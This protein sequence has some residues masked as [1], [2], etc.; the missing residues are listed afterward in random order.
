MNISDMLSQNLL[1]SGVFMRNPSS[2]ESSHRHGFTVMSRASSPAAILS[3][4]VLS[5]I[6]RGAARGNSAGNDEGS[7]DPNVS[8]VCWLLAT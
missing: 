1:E 2:A 5:I 3:Q 8:P 4:T 6:D 7:T